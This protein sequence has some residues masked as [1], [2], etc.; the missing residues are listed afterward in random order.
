MPRTTRIICARHKRN[1]LSHDYPPLS[2]AWVLFL[3]LFQHRAQFDPMHPNARIRILTSKLCRVPPSRPTQPNRARQKLA[4]LVVNH[5]S[6]LMYYTYIFPACV[7]RGKSLRLSLCRKS[8]AVEKP[9]NKVGK[10]LARVTLHL[11]FFNGFK[12]SLERYSHIL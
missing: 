3:P 9:H 8:L 7:A 1:A 5:I 2:G 10:H 12:S 4:W 6:T 11:V